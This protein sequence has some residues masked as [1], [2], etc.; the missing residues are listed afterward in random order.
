MENIAVST[1]N[2]SKSQSMEILLS[3]AN[4]SAEECCRM[5]LVNKA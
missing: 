1:K 5:G 3:G 4:Y 2:L